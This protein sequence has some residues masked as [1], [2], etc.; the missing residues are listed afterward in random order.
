MMRG[1]SVKGNEP[2][3]PKGNANTSMIKKYLTKDGSPTSPGLDRQQQ[4]NKV[5]KKDLGKKK[6]EIS[7]QS[8]EDI[9]TESELEISKMVE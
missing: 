2:K 3:T 5:K 7:D 1:R 8:T 4:G 6:G 9:S